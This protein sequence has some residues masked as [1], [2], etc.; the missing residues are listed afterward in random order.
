MFGFYRGFIPAAPLVDDAAPGN[1]A[2]HRLADTGTTESKTGRLIVGKMYMLLVGSVAL[3]VR[4]SGTDG[5]VDA[6]STTRDIVYP[7]N[8]VVPFTVDQYSK[9]VYVE[10]ADGAAAYEGFVV[11]YQS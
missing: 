10:A 7:P 2:P 5:L 6:V 3:R 1:R 9:Y 4:F 11:Q 8:A